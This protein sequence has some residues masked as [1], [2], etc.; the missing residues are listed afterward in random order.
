MSGTQASVSARCAALLNST[1]KVG[2]ELHTQ[3][4]AAF[5]LAIRDLAVFL[6]I[7]S[8]SSLWRI[9]VPPAEGA[10]VAARLQSEFPG[11]NWYL[12]WGGGLMW[13]LLPD[14]DPA[15]A[16]VVR[17]AIAP[18]KG[19]ATLLCGPESLRAAIDPFPIEP[20]TAILSSRVK[21]AFD[22]K[23]LLNPRRLHRDW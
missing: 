18:G 20:G 22:P 7:K 15:E 19:H 14:G 1:D 9:S 12:D 11:A 3:N 4:S 2:G 5:W 8:G 21:A 10:D 13:L 6:P 16:G 23:G 17:S